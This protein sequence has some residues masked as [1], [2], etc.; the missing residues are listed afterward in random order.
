MIADLLQEPDLLAAIRGELKLIRDIERATGRLSQASGNARD[1]V[2]LKTSLQQIPKLKNELQKLIERA[3]FGVE[4][5]RKNSVEAAVSAADSFT[6][7]A[8]RLPLQL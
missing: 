7:Q 5:S 2:A 8:T 1:L 6:T 4:D 3:S